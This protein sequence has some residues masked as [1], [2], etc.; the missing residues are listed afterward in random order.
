MQFWC[1]QK[2]FYA[3]FDACFG[4]TSFNLGTEITLKFLCALQ[5]VLRPDPTTSRVWS[6][7]GLWRRSA[8]RP[9][10]GRPAAR[11]EPR[12]SPSALIGGV[13]TTDGSH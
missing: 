7:Q 3:P 8:Q 9:S 1:Q 2:R 10:V 4:L 11:C 6:D 5:R 12:G 13:H